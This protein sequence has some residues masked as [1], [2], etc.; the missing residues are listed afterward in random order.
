MKHD[1]GQLVMV[2]LHGANVEDV[3][4]GTVVEGGGGRYQ[5]K[6]EGSFP[7]PITGKK[8]YGDGDVVEFRRSDGF[9]VMAIRRTPVIRR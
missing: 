8:P 9:S 2:R 1:V 3:A 4:W 6:V 7:D 5:V